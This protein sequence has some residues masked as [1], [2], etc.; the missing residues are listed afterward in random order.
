MDQAA[1]AYVMKYGRDVRQSLQNEVPAYFA[2]ANT[3]H[4][5]LLNAR[6]ARAA[7]GGQTLAVTIGNWYFGRSGKVQLLGKPG[8]GKVNAREEQ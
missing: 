3:T 4:T 1:R 2:T 8:E 7:I 5:A 6:F